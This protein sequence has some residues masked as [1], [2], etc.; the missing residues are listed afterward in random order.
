[1]RKYIYENEGCI[2]GGGEPLAPI[3]SVGKKSKMITSA[4]L[5]KGVISE[6][7]I[8]DQIVAPELNQKF[9]PIQPR[10]QELSKYD[11]VKAKEEIKKEFD[12]APE[13]P[14]QIVKNVD[15]IE[16]SVFSNIKQNITNSAQQQTKANPSVTKAGH[17]VSTRENLSQSGQ[18]NSMMG[19]KQVIDNTLRA[20]NGQKPKTLKTESTVLAMIS[21]RILEEV[22]HPMGFGRPQKILTHYDR[23]INSPTRHLKAG[24]KFNIATKLAQV[25]GDLQQDRDAIKK[26]NNMQ[27]SV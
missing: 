4:Y 13:L 2:S 26:I 11:I 1:M 25:K 14:S 5:K 20:A 8:I 6:N 10:A 12:N 19:S 17:L 27:K 24:E 21:S 15:S 3:N 16:E 7:V 9:A 18:A 22:S 23:T